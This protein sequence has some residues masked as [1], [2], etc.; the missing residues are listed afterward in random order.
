MVGSGAATGTGD[1]SR[2]RAAL[3]ALCATQIVSWGIVHHAFAVL[4]L[5]IT[6]VTGWPAGVTTAAFSLGLVV[7]AFAGIRI[8][9]IRPASLPR[10]GFLAFMG[11]ACPPHSPP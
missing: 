9:R 11:V 7:S 4:N 6:A 2:P 3:P 1:R 8:G 10:L 5:Q